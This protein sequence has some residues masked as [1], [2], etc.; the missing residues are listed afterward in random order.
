MAFNLEGP[1][2]ERSLSLRFLNAMKEDRLM[3]VIDDRIKNDSDA[4]LLEEVAELARQCLEMIGERRPT[5]KDVA[6]KLDRL[7]KVLQHPWVPAQH[8]PE[9]MQSLLRE[10]SVGSLEMI[11]TGNL[12][13]EKRI[14]QG[15]LESGR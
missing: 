15:L 13:M 14:V 10:S 2:T 1:E 12:S 7:S 8:N 4:G 9:E 11:S 6:E 5:M 3:D